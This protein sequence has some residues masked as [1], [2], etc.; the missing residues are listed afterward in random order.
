M[1]WDLSGFQARIT[2]FSLFPLQL[3]IGVMASTGMI[4]SALAA[5]RSESRDALR[6][7]SHDDLEDRV[8]KRTQEMVSANALLRESEERVRLLV[9]GVEDY[10][11]FGLDAA[12][13][14]T[15]WNSGAERTKGYRAVEI[16]GKHF[17]CFYTPEDILKGKPAELLY[18]AASDG[19]IREEGW[20]VRRDGSRFI[21]D[22]L[23][24]AI[25]DKTGALKGF[26]KI[27]RDITERKEMDERLQKSQD[28][29][30]EAQRIAH[31]GS[32]EWDLQ[33]NTLSWSDELYRIYGLPVQG[34]RLRYAGCHRVYSSPGS[35]AG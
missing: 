21:A 29:L 7:K 25:R 5:E 20:R 14:V 32:W 26:T 33:K 28:Q 8:E 34:V 18:L 6:I 2:T 9:E 1:A 22:V 24:T 19:R 11:I 4:F 15:T 35:L 3:F 30:T 12:G 17:S 10:A 31:I 23:I 16:L 27:T 13:Y